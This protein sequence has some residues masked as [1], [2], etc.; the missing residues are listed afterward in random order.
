LTN[1]EV[2]WNAFGDSGWKGGDGDTNYAGSG[3][4]APS[5]KINLIKDGLS[6][7]VFVG[8]AYAYCDRT[9]H[10]AFYSW[11]PNGGSYGHTFGLTWFIGI[12]GLDGASYPPTNLTYGMPNTLMFQVQPLP[13][14][15][16]ACPA[17]N[18]CCNPWVLQTPHNT[19]PVAMG[20]GS[21]RNISGQITQETWRYL[22]QPRDGQSVD[23]S[24]IN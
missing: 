8:E 12:G 17:G 6:N 16:A 7:T 21:I 1:Y 23:D 24:N 15:Y 20:D 13:M 3:Y 11:A 10:S 9:Y 14:T 18:D 19:L 4:A 5:Q 22:C 2:N